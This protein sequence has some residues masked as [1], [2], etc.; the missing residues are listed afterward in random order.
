MNNRFVI[1][2]LLLLVAGPLVAQPFTLSSARSD[3]VAVRKAP[4]TAP[5]IAWQVPQAKQV[6]EYKLTHTVT[7]RVQAADAVTRLEFVRNGVVLNRETRGFKR[8]GGV[9]FSE[10]IP[11][12]TGS[13]ELYVK[14]TNAIGTTTSEPRLIICQPDTLLAKS[15][16]IAGVFGQKRLAL[17]VA[18]GSYGRSSLKNPTNDGRAIKQQLEKLG[19][20][21]TYKEN[22]P[23]RNLKETVNSFIAELGSSNVGLFYYAG[24]G[25]MVNGETYLQPTDADPKT[26]T[27]VEFE[28]YSLRQIYASMARANATGA[29]L[30]FW[31]ACRNKPYR[32]WHRGAS[33]A[34]YALIQPSVGTMIIYATAPEKQAYDGDQENGLFTSELVKH[35]NQPNVDIYQLVLQVGQGLRERGF[36][37][38]PY[39]EGYIE[40]GFMF[41][42][43]N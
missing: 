20:A 39:F 22:L 8:A 30:I 26:E 36:N 6:I 13:N 5:L 23:L 1:L 10:V 12:V 42:V 27:D 16:P 2:A 7:V 3:W 35:I 11:L 34:S 38:P 4:A 21:V 19:F 9:E 43:S 41:K 14:A 31:D 37:Q 17:V 25:L 18:N 33:G 24:H 28:C 15:V 32:S 40:N 29:N